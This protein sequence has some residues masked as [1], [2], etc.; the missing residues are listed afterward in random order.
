MSSPSLLATCSCWFLLRSLTALNFSP[1]DSKL[2]PQNIHSISTASQ[3]F[4]PTNLHS[5]NPA[6]HFLEPEMITASCH[7]TAELMHIRG[8]LGI[9]TSPGHEHFWQPAHLVPRWEQYSKTV[10]SRYIVLAIQQYHWQ[11]HVI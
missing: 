1:S 7:T 6:M 4:S 8:W 5:Q 11:Y 9:T 10:H 2:P 3:E